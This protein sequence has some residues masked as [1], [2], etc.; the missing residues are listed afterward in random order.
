[1]AVV[2]VAPGSII[3]V[4]VLGSEQNRVIESVTDSPA[5]KETLK[6]QPPCNEQAHPPLDQDT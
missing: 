3:E 6:I 4:T 5:W 2:H 1:M